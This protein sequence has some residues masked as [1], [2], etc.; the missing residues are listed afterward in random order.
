VG[1]EPV[2]DRDRLDL[3]AFEARVA[4]DAR[5]YHAVEAG[6]PPAEVLQRETF[7]CVPGGQR[8]DP[9]IVEARRIDGKLRT[10]ARRRLEGSDMSS[11]P[12]SSEARMV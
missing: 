7:G 2:V 9:H 8:Y 4:V 3:D 10:G 1:C 11:A 5:R 6:L 12:T